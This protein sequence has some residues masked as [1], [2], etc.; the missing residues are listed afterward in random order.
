MT[1]P[2]HRL[3]VLVLAATGACNQ[4]RSEAPARDEPSERP[5]L[6]EVGTVQPGVLTDRW[7]YVGQ[8]QPLM[9][10]R[11]AAGVAGEVRDV[12]VRVGDPVQRG[13]RLVR[14]DSRLAKARMAAA[15]ANRAMSKEELAQ[16][17]RDLRRAEALGESIVPEVEIEQSATRTQ[18]L[19][20]R[21][22][23]LE[24]AV[25]EA[26]EQLRL[27]R[28]DA[29]F[30]A[31]VAARH[32]DPGDWVQPGDPVLDLVAEDRVEVIVDA[33][34]ELAPHV[35]VGGAVTLRHERG[36]VTARILGV[37]RA[38]DPITRTIKIRVVPDEPATWLLVG[39]AVDAE[40]PVERRGEG[41][42]VSRDAV[43]TG[44][45][46]S[47]VIEVVDGKARSVTIEILATADDRALVR[48]EGLD[49][50]DTVV[51]RG[52]ERLRPGQAV[53]LDTGAD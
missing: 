19:A 15:R 29:P 51:V 7:V 39:A 26:R 37:V 16:A 33:A 18:T 31:T 13:D 28:V 52:N 24:A 40:F 50:G 45:V 42:V 46:D 36:T 2:F 30:D 34:P 10:A 4:A 38:L 5:A 49:P 11:V 25:R 44:A 6:V 8:V 41:V 47:R 21:S 35:E 14:I 9:E 12:N 32:V 23:S 20:S 53:T 1:P 17:E 27:H 22:Q 43:V 3:A 48:G